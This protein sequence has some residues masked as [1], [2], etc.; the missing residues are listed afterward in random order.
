MPIQTINP[1]S[2]QL[3]KSFT[4]MSPEEVEAAMTAT[5]YSGMVEGK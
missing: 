2:N 3:V 5:V 1:N 4:E